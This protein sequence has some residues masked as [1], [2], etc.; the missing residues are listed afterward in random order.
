MGLRNDT[1]VVEAMCCG[2]LLG[3]RLWELER[4]QAQAENVGGVGRRGMRAI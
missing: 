1:E 4:S 2:S 3:R